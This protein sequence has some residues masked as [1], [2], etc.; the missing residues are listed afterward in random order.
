MPSTRPRDPGPSPDRTQVRSYARRWPAEWIVCQD[1]VT[2]RGSAERPRRMRQRTKT[3]S[4][5]I[6]I[7]TRRFVT[8]AAGDVE[9]VDGF[10]RTR[11]DLARARWSRSRSVR[12]RRM[13]WSARTAVRRMRR[14]R[15]DAGAA[16]SASTSRSRFSTNWPISFD[17]TSASTPRPNCAT[18]P[19][20]DRSVGDVDLGA[21]AV[22]GHR[23]DDLRLGVALPTRVAAGR[24]EHDAGAPPRRPRR[25]WPCPCTAR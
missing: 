5:P 20:I 3:T 10:G 4:S 2:S 1:R 9:Q 22:L 17:D 21:A 8:G 24:V 19:V 15:R 12:P 23:H 25:A 18:L 6:P 14:R 11:L 13:P 7:G 16:M